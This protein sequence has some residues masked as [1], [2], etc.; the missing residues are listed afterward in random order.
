MGSKTDILIIGIGNPY[1]HDDGVGF[2]VIDALENKGVDAETRRIKPDG[3]SLLEAWK[4]REL[5]I[6]VDA[7]RGIGPVGTV[8]YFNALNDEIQAEL[9]P[10]STHSLS[11]PETLFLG[12]TL[13]Q[14][15]NNLWIYAIEA[16]ELG[17]GTDLSPEVRKAA[18]NVALE[19]E[20]LIKE[21]PELYQA[22]GSALKVGLKS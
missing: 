17:H 10:V 22:A 6:I 14:L 3:Y 20:T 13:N 12:K 16:G 2:F 11:L 1:R 8:R 19:I 4:G 18:L 5:V 7:A 15:P 9:S 21:Y